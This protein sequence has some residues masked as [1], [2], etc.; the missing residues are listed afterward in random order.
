M[1]QNQRI[2]QLSRHFIGIGD[3]VRRQITAIK[4]HAFNHVQFAFKA[5]GFF[6]RNHAFIADLIHRFGNHRTNF[7]FAIGRDCAD[8]R[9]FLI[10]FHFFRAL[11]NI[12]QC[13][14]GSLV[15]TAFQIHRVHSGG[16]RFVTF[17]DNRLCQNGCGCGAVTGHIIG[18]RSHFADHLCAHIF[19]LIFQLNFF[20]NRNTVF[21]GARRAE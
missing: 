6:H 1:Q 5:F 8:L 9:N 15:D 19:K 7:G 13:R 10:G 17:A 3:E 2:F 21:G 4:L 11:F 12:G 18:A 20:S 16:N 14:S